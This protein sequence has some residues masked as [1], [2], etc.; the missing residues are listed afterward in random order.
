MLAITPPFRFQA[1]LFDTSP[2]TLAVVELRS[3][4]EATEA[5]LLAELDTRGTTDLDVPSRKQLR[6]EALVELLRIAQSAEPGAGTLPR[7]EVTLL[8]HNHHVTDWDHG[9]P[10]NLDNLVAL[11]RYHHGVTHRTGWT[12][13]LDHTQTPPLDHPIR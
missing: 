4:L 13:H 9:G 5:R 8:L 12:L 11:C 1:R 3:L 7:A 10:T 6:A 2:P